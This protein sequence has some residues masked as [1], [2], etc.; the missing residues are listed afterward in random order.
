[1]RIDFLKNH[2]NLTRTCAHWGLTTWGH[3]NDKATLERYIQNYTNHHHIDHLPLTLLALH[4]D[5][6]VGMA[7][8]RENDGLNNDQKPW[9]GS[10]YVTPQFRSQGIGTALIHAIEAQAK[11]LGFDT[12]NL[13]TFEPHLSEWYSQLGWVVSGHDIYNSH[14][15]T[16]MNKAI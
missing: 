16:V 6:P 4:N 13:L 2:P 14:P 7:S 15:V 11:Q 8:L 1:M 5:Y 12:L 9:L 10:L 3:Y